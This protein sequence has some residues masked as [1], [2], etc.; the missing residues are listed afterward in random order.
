[1]LRKLFAGMVAMIFAA[2]PV[3]S[4]NGADDTERLSVAAGTFIGSIVKSSV[5]HLRSIGAD[6]DD[7][8]FTA[9][10]LKVLRGED[11]GFTQQSANAYIESVIMQKTAMVDTFSVASQDAFLAQAAAIP[12]AVV[13]PSGLVFITES[14]GTGANPGPADGVT[15][16]YVGRFY[17]GEEFDST[18]TPIQFEVDHVTPGFGEGL[19]LMREGGR[20]RLVMPAALG[21]GPEGIPG[22]IPGNA[23]LDFTVDLIKV[24]PEK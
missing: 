19:Q 8:I 2:I 14:E 7:E 24:T 23:A 12:G 15:V 22:A 20:Y 13:T 18:D 21:Y 4:Q 10:I 1:M 3:F 9:T 11:T 5:D 6:V 16:T 17:D